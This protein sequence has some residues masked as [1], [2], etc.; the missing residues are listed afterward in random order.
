MFSLSDTAHFYGISLDEFL[1]KPINDRNYMMAYSET[2]SNMNAID[3]E[4]SRVKSEMA[5]K[6]KK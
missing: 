4:D 1:N 5:G 6:D 3:A 2:R